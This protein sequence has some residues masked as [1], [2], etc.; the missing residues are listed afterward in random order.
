MVRKAKAKP[1]RPKYTV[2]RDNNEHDNHG[3]WFG[4]SDS[5]AGTIEKNLYTA[6]YSLDGYYD[7]K[8]FVVER[9]GTVSEFVGNI[10]HKE[11]WDDFKNELVRLEEFTHPFVICEFPLACLKS[12]PVDSDIPKH[13]WPRL[14]VNPNFLMKRMQEI[15]MH[16]K[17]KFIFCDTQSF[18]WEYVCGLFK[19]VVDSRGPQA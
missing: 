8:Y 6:D 14:R 18:A 17:T 4:P 9:K 15:E 12:F 3:W 11:K 13:I 1:E 2:F 5:C 7:D 16:F 10:T 19:R